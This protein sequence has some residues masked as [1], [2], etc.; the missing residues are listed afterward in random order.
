MNSTAYSLPFDESVDDVLDSAPCGF[1]S[2]LP[3]GTITQVN[4]TFLSWTGHSRAALLAGQRF[5]D[6]L[7]V[8]DRIF[9]KTHFAPLL[10][11]QGFVKEIACQLKRKDY[12]PLRVL[13]NS[14]LKLDADGMP[15]FIRTIVFDAT[16]RTK[17][18]EELRRVHNE[19]QQLAAIVTASGDAIISLGLDL[20]VRTWNPGATLLFGYAQNEAVGR[21]TDELIVP[22]DQLAESIRI[23]DTV[24]TGGKAVRQAMRRHKGGSLMRVEITASP[25][26]DAERQITA[27]SV[28]Y[29][30]IAERDVA[31]DALRR[32]EIRYRRLFEAAHD[33]VLILDPRTRKIIDA[34]PFMTTLLGYARDQLVGM[35][36]YEIG[37]HADA[38]ASRDMFQTLKVTH[39]V[40][41]KALPLQNQ[42]GGVREVEVVANLYDENGHSII[43]CNV[44]DN[45]ERKRAED[46]L[47]ESAARLELAYEAAGIGAW[48]VDLMTSRSVWT[49]ELYEMLGIDTDKETSAELFFDCVHPDDIE[50]LRSTFTTSIAT[51]S[52]FNS[53]FRII[54]ADGAIRYLAGLGRVI[55]EID[56]KPVRMIGINQDITARKQTADALRLSESRLRAYLTATTDA[57]YRMSPDWS[58]MLQ[59]SGGGGGGG[60]IAETERPSKS[61]LTEYIDPD[62]QQRVRSAISQAIEAKSAFDFEHRVRR[63]DGRL[64]W[65]R[66][67]AL[68][69]LDKWG[70]IV[71]WLGAASDITERKQAETELRESHDTYLRLI[72]N[73]PFGIYLVDSHFRLAQVSASTKTVFGAI[74]PLIGRDF[75]EIIRAIWQEPLAGQIIARFRRTL[76]TGEGFHSKDTTGKRANRD[77]EESYDWQIERV[78][79]PGGQFGIVCY[80]YDLTERHRHQ[81]HIKLLMD[82]VNHRSKNLLAVVAAIA[83]QT[84][85]LGDPSTYVNHLSKRI[86]GMAASQDLLVKNQWTHIE[87]SELVHA[88]LSFFNHLIG[89]RV[90]LDGPP[91]NLPPG[92][93]EGIGMALH[94]LATNA[95]KYGALS[96]AS[97]LV[98]INWDYVAAAEPGFTLQWL[99]EGGPEVTPPTRKGFGDTVIRYMVEEAVQ[100]KVELEYRTSGLYWK[101]TAPS[102]ILLTAEDHER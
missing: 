22:E 17:H 69:I 44:R 68:P 7:T 12:E 73:N 100:G 81:Q 40:R 48:D 30:D 3:D 65:T 42:D 86:Q 31:E 45:T 102:S 60:V 79:L 28:V 6:L 96:N 78:S 92:A 77:T 50:E 59:L 66:S 85:F 61:W 39:Q 41:Y 24:R 8:P 23:F 63:T 97:G 13:V 2:T 9:Y 19:A 15:L 4:A 1:I 83:R 52:P 76:E 35:E 10:R 27:I 29:R 43:Q 51:R 99:E 46:A 34:N 93:A 14:S 54:R 5:Q 91:I 25:I 16:D 49:P 67:R 98:H 64:G 55:E 32:S 58:E 56:G 36:L 21:T 74:V 26:R 90:L 33:G 80:Y 101:L 37:F 89:T 11:A 62:D 82:E 94:E 47:R 71:E 38:Q 70:T 18:E 53:E 75:A 20:V 87:L 84:A 72:E 57:I 95:L 88:Q